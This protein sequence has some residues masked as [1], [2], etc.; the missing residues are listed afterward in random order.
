MTASNPNW[1]EFSLY[2]VPGPASST[3]NGLTEFAGEIQIPSTAAGTYS[4]QIG[5]NDPQSS[6]ASRNIK[7]EYSSPTKETFGSG[8][9]G[10]RYIV[11]QIN[12]NAPTPTPA[13]P[14][15]LDLLID[16]MSKPHESTVHGIN[17]NW[18]WGTKPRLGTGVNIPAIF[19]D[20][21]F[22]PWGVV[23]TSTQGSQARNTRVQIRKVIFDVKRNGV[24]SRVGYNSTDN[25]LAGAF[26]KDYETNENTAAD[27]RP[28][29]ADGISVKL[30]D[31][32][33][34]FHFYTSNRFRF[35]RG[36]QEIIV[37]FEA[38]LIVDDPSK[39][40]DRTS[41]RLLA[42][43]G[44]DFWKN[45]S[46]GWDPNVYSN[47]DFA[48]GRFRYVTNEWAVFTSHTFGSAAEVNDYLANEPSL[49]PR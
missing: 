29:G 31:A 6:G 7:L 38:R 20:P 21:H 37:R 16:D 33:G 5:V 23:G 45:A 3:W 40:D 18:S 12:V 36:A 14:L 44:G 4:I 17:P 22:V 43:S 25:S 32:G 35:A 9:I 8:E 30:P 24:W 49:S 48:I 41:A 28:H 39:A 13:G 2:P 34:S 27:K 47:D 19:D 42:C 1:F 10:Y 46:Q 15:S 26:Y 11:S